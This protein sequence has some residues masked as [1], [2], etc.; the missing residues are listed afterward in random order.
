MK[1]AWALLL[2]AA[3]GG[4][5]DQ[6][7]LGDEAWHAGRWPDAVAAYKAAG[8]SPRLLA[9]YADAALAAGRLLDAADAWTRLGSETTERAGEAAAGLARTANAAERV[10]DQAALARAILGLRRV[11]PTWP[12]G[13]LA[14]RLTR[15]AGLSAQDAVDVLPVA[16]AGAPGRAGGDSLLLALGEAQR[17]RRSCEQAVPVLEGL[18]HR[19][20]LAEVRTAALASLAAC[21]LDLGL[22]ALSADQ[23][24]AA[25]RWLDRAARRDPDGL[26]GRRALLRYGDARLRQGDPFSATL[27]WQ[28]VASARVAPD[29]ITILALERLRTAES[30]DTNSHPV[31]VPDRP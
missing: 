8:T 23:A 6:E 18:E 13:R 16:L 26:T 12:L 28:T 11:A 4:G 5:P 14:L 24:G 15:V 30:A 2:L 21:E 9:K 3:C 25:E 22:A 7:R 20:T 19:A 31:A 1:R 29:S 17:A 27:A 10:D